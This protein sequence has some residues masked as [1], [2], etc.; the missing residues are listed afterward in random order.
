V[1]IFRN[2]KL[3]LGLLLWSIPVYFLLPPIFN[4][5]DDGDGAVLHDE[6]GMAAVSRVVDRPTHTFE[7]YR[8]IWEQNVFKTGKGESP[9]KEAAV[10]EVPLADG[11]V[12]L[13]L[14]GTAVMENP[15][16]SFAT[17]QH[18]DTGLQETY[19][20]GSRLG[21]VLIKKIMQDQVIID[22]GGEE[23]ILS[24]DPFRAIGKGRVIIA[25]EP[26][27]PRNVSASAYPARLNREEVAR[28]YPDYPSFLK[29]A[30]L[31]SQFQAGSAGGILIRNIDAQG[32]F[33]KMGL[34]EGDVIK[35]VNGEPLVSSADA[36]KI[37]DR[38]KHGGRLNLE[39]QRG[40]ESMRLRLYVG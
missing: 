25:K 36:V 27:T 2:Y 22:A 21:R 26:P 17:I 28:E 13:K 11:G 10:D 16:K 7:D 19:W 23:M 12:G 30:G 14:V 31:D 34:Q 29:T 4:T 33:G 39:V 8:A 37:Y 38:L 15:G 24:M 6:A 5:P 9:A 35:E 18:L 3:L 32:V 20:E 1:R 40:K